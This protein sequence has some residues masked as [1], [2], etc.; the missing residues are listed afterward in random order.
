MQMIIGTIGIILSTVGTVWTLWSILV[1]PTKYV[2]TYEEMGNRNKD[3]KKTKKHTIAGIILII[4]GGILQG[5]S[6]WL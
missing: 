3:F 6:L 4:L 1:T 5:I 2:G